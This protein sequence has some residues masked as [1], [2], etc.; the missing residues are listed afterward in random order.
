MDSEVDFLLYR[1][2]ILLVQEYFTF[3]NT[4]GAAPAALVDKAETNLMGVGLT[5]FEVG[6]FTP[7]F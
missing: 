3:R 7:T 6:V 1:G 2:A 5:S 4:T